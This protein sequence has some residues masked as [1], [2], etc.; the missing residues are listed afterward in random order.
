MS[1]LSAD[2][3]FGQTSF[4]HL[5]RT[6]GFRGRTAASLMA[7]VCLLWAERVLLLDVTKRV[8]RHLH[9]FLATAFCTL[10]ILLFVGTLSIAV[11]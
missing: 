6:A 7:A 2:R 10:L 5:Q 8:T 11:S 9:C 3:E 4:L 1:V